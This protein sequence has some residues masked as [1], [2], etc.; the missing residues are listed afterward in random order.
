MEMQFNS[1]PWQYLKSN[2]RQVLNQ[3]QTLEVRLTDGMPDIG[4]VLCAWG[5]PMLRSKE[6][7]TDG[8]TVTGGVCV[9]VLYA[10]EDGGCPQSVQAWLPFQGKWSFPDS[11]REGVI[12]AQCLLRGVDARTLSARKIMVRANVGILAEALEQTQ[13]E[14]S[15][16]PEL[17]EQVYVL[18][19]TYPLCL[20]VEAGERLLNLEENF[21]LPAKPQYIAACQ[22]RPLVTEENVV[23]GKIVF[24]GTAYVDL[25]FIGQDSQPYS[26]VLE[27]PF[28]QYGELDRDYDKEASGSVTMAISNLETEFSDDGIRIKC[29]LIAQY[30]VRENRLLQIAEDAYSPLRRVTPD[31]QMLQLPAIL[32]RKQQWIEATRECNE[33][34]S[35]VVHTVFM[36]DHPTCYRDAEQLWLE[37]PGAFQM[38]YYD[39]DGVLQ[40][41]TEPWSHTMTLPAADQSILQMSVGSEQ[42]PNAVRQGEA[43]QLWGQMQMDMTT[44]ANQQIPMVTALNIGPQ[45]A[46]EENRPSLLLQRMGEEGLW[47]LAKAS[48]S[49]VDAIRQANGLQDEPVPGQM[50]LIPVICS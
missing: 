29:G 1:M 42:Q 23:G 32:D 3:E 18:S 17:P 30:I 12:W 13:L 22:I 31:I 49:T 27:M 38:L 6:W 33:N 50:L 19:K 21:S 24:R 14:I 48:G 16:C 40:A 39:T 43:M 7:R 44:V 10:P 45:K 36:P 15:Q 9:W 28:A 35:Q 20:P 4:R 2:V 11:H 41:R 25:L 47:N 46:M 8:M 34:V 26:Q 5:Q 37:F